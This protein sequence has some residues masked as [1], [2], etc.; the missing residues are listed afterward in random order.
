MT[1][2]STRTPEQ[3]ASIRD[4]VAFVGRMSDSLVRVGPFRLGVD[5]V[6]SW[7]PG[8]GEAYSAIAGAFIIVQGLRAG[9]PLHI[10]LLCAALMASRTTISAIPLAGPVAA[11]LFT[12]HRWS[13]KMVVR[14]IDAK[15]PTHAPPGGTPVFAAA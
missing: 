6:L 9:V 13:A 10:L 12:A 4:S 15:L 8:L 11:D 1:F 2:R 3:L 7:L 14:A 5:G